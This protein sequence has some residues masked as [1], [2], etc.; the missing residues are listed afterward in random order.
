VAIFRYSF[1]SGLVRGMFFDD[2]RGM[3]CLLSKWCSRASIR[4]RAGRAGRVREGTVIQFM[5]QAF[6]DR[7]GEFDEAPILKSQ[8]QF[9]NVSNQVT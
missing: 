6:H 4:Q 8:H 3:Q 1:S 9:S 2:Q 7:L 5:T